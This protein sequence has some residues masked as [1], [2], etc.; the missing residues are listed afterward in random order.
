M[1]KAQGERPWDKWQRGKTSNRTRIKGMLRKVDE[2]DPFESAFENLR[3]QVRH[4]ACVYI[5]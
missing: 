3:H 4:E 5:N 2:T 1:R